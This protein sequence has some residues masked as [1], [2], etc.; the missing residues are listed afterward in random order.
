MLFG[1][2]AMRDSTRVPDVLPNGQSR[3]EALGIQFVEKRGGSGQIPRQTPL[4]RSASL[5]EDLIP[6]RICNVDLTVSKRHLDHTHTRQT[7]VSGSAGTLHSDRRRLDMPEVLKTTSIE[8]TMRRCHSEAPKPSLSKHCDIIQNAMAT[9][10]AAL[11]GRLTTPKES[12]RRQ[13]SSPSRPL[14]QAIHSKRTRSRSPSTLH[15]AASSAA[16]ADLLA[17]YAPREPLS[18]QK[19]ASSAVLTPPLASCT[20]REET[21]MGG[22]CRRA[23][24]VEETPS[25]G[26]DH[27]CSQDVIIATLSD[28][29]V[30][31]ISDA[32]SK[33]D[34]K[35]EDSLS[36]ISTTISR[37][38]SAPAV[39]SSLTA[40]ASSSPRIANAPGFKRWD[41]RTARLVE[42]QMQKL[43][44]AQQKK[45]MKRVM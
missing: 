40:S 12:P 23:L 24:S 8:H 37:Q 21:P 27:S 43:V 39:G 13:S 32:R 5:R 29:E 1:A 18:L 33:M 9:Q 7:H 36:N 28:L 10:A 17:L 30:S 4:S 38:S 42:E 20:P 35:P 15:K 19:A 3:V 14:T 22:L 25:K 2:T 11:A 45:S 34:S 16:L 31:L 6:R 41:P 26:I 44:K